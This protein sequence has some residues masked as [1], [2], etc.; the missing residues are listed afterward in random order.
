MSNPTTERIVIGGL[1]AIAAILTI[2]LC[3]FWVSGHW[4]AGLIAR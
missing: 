4:A 3:W 1:I 2:A